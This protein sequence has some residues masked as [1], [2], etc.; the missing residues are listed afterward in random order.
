MKSVLDAFEWS[1]G[2]YEKVYATEHKGLRQTI[3]S[4][5]VP[6][7]M[8]EFAIFLEDDIEVSPY[9]FEYSLACVNRYGQHQEQ[10]QG[11]ARYVL[12]CSLYRPIFSQVTNTFQLV[13][14]GGV[15]FLMQD[16]SSWGAV[17]FPKHWKNFLDWYKATNHI[18]PLIPNSITNT[19]PVAASWKKYLI[20]MSVEKGL[21]MVFPNLPNNMT[22]TTNH[23]EPGTNDKGTGASALEAK[24]KF[25]LPLMTVQDATTPPT[26]AFT[27]D[28]LVPPVWEEVQV[29]DIHRNRLDAP[30]DMEHEMTWF[31]LATAVVY[32]TEDSKALRD[33]IQHYALMAHSFVEVVVVW[34]A[35]VEPATPLSSPAS[36]SLLPVRSITPTAFVHGN[37]LNRFLP[38][39]QRS[40]WCV[41]L[42]EVGVLLADQ[43]VKDGFRAWKQYMDAVVGFPFEMR[44]YAAGQNAGSADVALTAVSIAAK[45]V[46]PPTCKRARPPFPNLL[47]PSA[48]FVHGKFL[49][50]FTHQTGW[51][52]LTLAREA[53][54]AGGAGADLLFPAAVSRLAKQPTVVVD[55]APEGNKTPNSTVA[56][57]A[58]VG[59]AG[60]VAAL[61]KGGEPLA[62][63]LQ[64]VFGIM[65][66]GGEPRNIPC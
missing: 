3:L 44:V 66:K 23:L 36:A 64:P 9:Y 25:T 28:I 22:L 51:E 1:H 56:L 15:P 52:G 17:Y 2:P 7:A 20:R 32:A 61:E 45:D 57:T 62:A 54:A 38:I 12:G 58:G 27:M 30:K 48:V 65:W 33:T 46:V 18:N 43:S 50:E 8:D 29:F 11:P 5:W 39:P 47:L 31:D 4:S 24:K 55:Q 42:V 26:A 16:V 63:L 41:F 37:R 60:A 21:G 49:H 35:S 14:T 59:A 34:D 53:V 13:D 6:T 10:E 40:T 19:W